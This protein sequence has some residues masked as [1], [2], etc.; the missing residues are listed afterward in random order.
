MS[1]DTRAIGSM[2]QSRATRM[3]FACPA[4]NAGLATPT[5]S[6]SIVET[7]VMTLVSFFVPV[8]LAVLFLL[9]LV[10]LVLVCCLTGLVKLNSLVGLITPRVCTAVQGV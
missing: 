7:S 8:L 2:E 3:S 5:K 9:V 4:M 1:G 6:S 10:H